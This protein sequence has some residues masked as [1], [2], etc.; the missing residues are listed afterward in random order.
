MCGNNNGLA[1][2]DDTNMA[3]LA[4]NWNVT[5]INAIIAGM[6]GFLIFPRGDVLMHV[7]VEMSSHEE[8]Q[9]AQQSHTS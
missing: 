5:N 2:D 7:P 6:C 1:S 9:H 3:T 8:G 4:N